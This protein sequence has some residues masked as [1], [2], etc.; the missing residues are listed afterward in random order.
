MTIKKKSPRLQRAEGLVLRRL[1]E[2]IYREIHDPRIGMVTITHVDLASDYSLAK[3]Y[4]A[5]LANDPEAM[6]QTLTV[7]KNASKFLRSMLAQA[8]DLRYTP[9]L[10]FVHDESL[11]RAQRM[12]DIL[13]KFPDKPKEESEE[14]SSEP[15]TQ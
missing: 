7:L 1:S 6:K 9:Q 15:D 4:I 3:I 5:S 8:A 13:D 11:E 14:D 12:H 2:I 10:K